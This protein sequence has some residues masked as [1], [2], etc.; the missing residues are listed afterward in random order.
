MMTL[1][2]YEHEPETIR[3]T[4]RSLHRQ[5]RKDKHLWRLECHV[6]Q[7]HF[8]RG[9]KT[10]RSKWDVNKTKP[11]AERSQEQKTACK[12]IQLTGARR[13][14]VSQL[15]GGCQRRSP[16]CLCMR[17]RC[18][19][20]SSFDRQVTCSEVSSLLWSMPSIHTRWQTRSRS[21]GP[22][23][24]Y[25]RGFTHSHPQTHHWI[26]HT[27]SVNPITNVT[28][29]QSQCELEWKKWQFFETYLKWKSK[30]GPPE[31]TYDTPIKNS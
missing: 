15:G 18:I 25:C 31:A 8:I 3:P 2:G 19:P 20:P 4:S 12:T 14:P 5:P 16:R 21:Y 10:D 13:I 24:I 23:T 9:E 29:H 28:S 30:K 27:L 11:G 6:W 22:F 17:N 7:P 1:M 26:K